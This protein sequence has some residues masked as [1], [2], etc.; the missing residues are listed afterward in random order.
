MSR[1]LRGRLAALLVS[2]FALVGLAVTPAGADAS[3]ASTYLSAVNL[4][5]YCRDTA[6]GTSVQDSG[7]PSGWSCAVNGANRPLSITD[8]CRYQFAELVSRGYL[9]YEDQVN[10]G[11]LKRSCYADISVRLARGGMDL[12]GYCASKGWGSAYNDGRNVDGWFC[13]NSQRIK[14]NDACKWQRAGD[15]ASGYV[16]AAAYADYGAWNRIGCVAL[17]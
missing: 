1:S 15:V 6:A 14:L 16:L 4:N 13:S 2:A 10:A 11:P 9:V 3:A 8:A 12:S 5:A 17:A 7:S